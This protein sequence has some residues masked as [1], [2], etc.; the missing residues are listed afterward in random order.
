MP[1]KAIGEGFEVNDFRLIGRT[2]SSIWR[3]GDHFMTL[4]SVEG[5]EL[6]ARLCC[7]AIRA[8]ARPDLIAGDAASAELF[9]RQRVAF[10]VA[11]ALGGSIDFDSFEPKL[12]EAA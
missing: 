9:A 2:H 3:A 11:K 12:K 7:E 4:E 6:L 5:A 10:A 1:S 8:A